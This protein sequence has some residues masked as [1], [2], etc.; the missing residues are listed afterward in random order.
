MAISLPQF[1]PLS[2]QPAELKRPPA[3]KPEPGTLVVIDSFSTM[4]EFENHGDQALRA[5]R[6]HGFKGPTQKVSL[7]QEAVLRGMEQK[8]GQPSVYQKLGSIRTELS[9]PCVTPQ[10][11]RELL[12]QEAL[13]QQVSLLGDATAELDQLKASGLKNSAV[14]LSYGT[15]P[16]HIASSKYGEIAQA[17]PNPSPFQF[18][19]HNSNVMSALGV[20][21]QNLRHPDP[22]ISGPERARL[23]QGLI[24]LAESSSS[25]PELKQAKSEYLKAVKALES[26]KNSVVVSSGNQ[27]QVANGLAKDAHGIR[28]RIDG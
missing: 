16:K 21:P 10:R 11:T 25:H 4:P 13:Y 1:N 26:Q 6:Q 23:Q 27:E 8:S 2:A 5:A 17:P 20:T 18:D 3:V 19:H 15:S 12:K 22:K 7:G 28:P 14:N 9:Q 24:D